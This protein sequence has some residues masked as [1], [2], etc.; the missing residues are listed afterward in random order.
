M[1]EADA[2]VQEAKKIGKLSN[3]KSYQIIIN[4]R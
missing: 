4:A 2:D 1:P 3:Y